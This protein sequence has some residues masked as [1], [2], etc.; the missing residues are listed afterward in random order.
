MINMRIIIVWSWKYI[1][2][3]IN[4]DLESWR[5]KKDHNGISK[6]EVWFSFIGLKSIAFFCHIRS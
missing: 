5:F 3:S 6:G 4:G 1:S 2:C